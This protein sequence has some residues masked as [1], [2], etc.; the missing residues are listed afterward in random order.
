MV[1]TIFLQFS[2]KI[3]APSVIGLRL[4]EREALADGVQGSQQPAA[5]AGVALAPVDDVA[6]PGDARWPRGLEKPMGF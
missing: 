3:A 5:A 2:P 1:A 4:R 6:W